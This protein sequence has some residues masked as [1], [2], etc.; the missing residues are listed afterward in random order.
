M[1][2]IIIIGL[3]QYPFISSLFSC[4]IIFIYL[5]VFIILHPVSNKVL[6][7][8]RIAVEIS[9]TSLFLLNLILSGFDKVGKYTNIE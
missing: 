1:I 3:N 8:I 4:I 5:I 2:T 7:M 9:L 6:L